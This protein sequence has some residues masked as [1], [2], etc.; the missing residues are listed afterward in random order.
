M[1]PDQIK[2]AR[3][4]RGWSKA[5]LARRAGVSALTIAGAESGTKDPHAKTLKAIEAAL[6][7]TVVEDTSTD[8]A[9]AP[10]PTQAGIHLHLPPQVEQALSD[11]GK[12]G[13]FS[14]QTPAQVAEDLLCQV[15]R[16]MLQGQARYWG[17][18]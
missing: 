5:E 3:T 7:S 15:V 14:G 9:H 4:T 10:T 13:L 6:T 1:T 12:T 18:A 16:E 11:F 8:P 2:Q 17:R